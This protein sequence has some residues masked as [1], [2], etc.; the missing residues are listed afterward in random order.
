MVAAYGPDSA[1]PPGWTLQEVLDEKSMTRADLA[2]RTG[3]P[4]K[5]VGRI[6]NGRAPI[7]TDTA[8]RLERETGI[9]ARLWIN[10]ESRYREHQVRLGKNEDSAEAGG[11][12][13]GFAGAGGRVG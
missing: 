10:L 7:T 2:R 4:L 1:A 6:M 3:L 11:G 8:V 12:G 9:P 13:R 5:L